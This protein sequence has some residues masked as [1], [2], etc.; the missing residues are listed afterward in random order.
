MIFLFHINFFFLF[1][2]HWHSHYSRANLNIQATATKHSAEMI[3]YIDH[4]T[5]NAQAHL[6]IWTTMTVVPNIHILLFFFSLFFLLL[7]PKSHFIPLLSKH[8]IEMENVVTKIKM[9]Y[10]K[11]VNAFTL[12][13]NIHNN[14]NNNDNHRTNQMKN[15]IRQRT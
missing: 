8:Q 12:T 6:N 4:Y 10:N 2:W 11:K 13:H 1:C 3:C 15:R 5:A 9:A 14:H 7:L